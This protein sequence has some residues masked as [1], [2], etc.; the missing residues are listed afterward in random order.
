MLGGSPSDYGVVFDDFDDF[1][2]PAD[3]TKWKP[4]IGKMMYGLTDD[5]RSTPSYMYIANNVLQGKFPPEKFGALC[6]RP[7]R[8]TASLY[9]AAASGITSGLMILDQGNGW[10]SVGIQSPPTGCSDNS[11]IGGA[12]AGI[13]IIA[14]ATSYYATRTVIGPQDELLHTWDMRSLGD[15]TV[16]WRVD[17]SAWSAPVAVTEFSDAGSGV[18]WAIGC[19]GA[20]A[21]IDYFG[22]F[23]KVR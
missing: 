20:A 9:T 4:K 14:T 3:D 13:N 15:N 23:Y 11:L 18:S 7:W 2:D 17:G 5:H 6:A 10:A 16:Q 21:F 19:L 12:D 1:H 8:M 22:F